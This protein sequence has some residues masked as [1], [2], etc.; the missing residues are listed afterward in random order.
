[1]LQGMSSGHPNNLHGF[2]TLQID[3]IIQC[4]HGSREMLT[5]SSLAHTPHGLNIFPYT[6]KTILTRV[7]LQE[8]MERNAHGTLACLHLLLL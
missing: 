6:V 5:Q 4:P 2:D 3:C 1:M 8:S 7:V